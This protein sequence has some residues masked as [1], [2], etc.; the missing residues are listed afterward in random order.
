MWKRTILS[1]QNYLH[2]SLFKKYLSSIYFEPDSGDMTVKKQKSSFHV[3]D[4]LVWEA[5]NNN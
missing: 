5:E 2:Y 3:A 4:S 1:E